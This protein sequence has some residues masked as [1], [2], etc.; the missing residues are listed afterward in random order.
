MK[1]TEVKT[2]EHLLKEYATP[3]GQQTTGNTGIGSVAKKMAGQAGKSL[4]KKVGGSVGSATSM[5][6]QAIKGADSKTTQRLKSIA[7]PKTS[8]AKITLSPT[9]NGERNIAEPV[10]KTKAGKVEKGA[11]IY[12]QYGNYAG[13]VDSPLGDNSAGAGADAVAILNKNN[14]YEVKTGDDEVFVQNPEAKE[15]DEGK[16]SKIANRRGKKRKIKKLKRI[17]KKI[18][19]KSLKEADPK[20]F[21]I[22]FNRQSVAKEALDAPVRCGFEAE[23]FFYNAD[24][25]TASDDV[26]NMSISDVEYEFGDLP[27]SAYE[28]YQ[29]WLREKAMDE[30]LPDLIDNWIEENRDE[31]EYIQDFMDSGNGPTEDAVEEY[32]ENY[33]EDN[34]NE[35]ENREE[36]GWELDNW[37]R[38]FINEEYEDEYEDFLRDI[39]NDEDHLV[40][41]AIEEAEGDY[42][43][44]EYVSD[45]YYSMSE[46]LDDFSYDYS[47]ENAGVDQVADIL[48]NWI[49]KSSEFKDYPEVGDYGDTYTT[50][51]YS[52]EPDSSIEADEGAGAEIISPVFSSPR[53]MLREMKSL[54]EWGE[55]QFGT[56]NSTGLHVTMSWQAEKKDPN[57]LKMALLLGDPYLLA[58]FGRLKNTYTKSQYNSL[59]KYASDIQKGQDNNLKALE[60]QLSKGIDSGKFN[61]IHFK[62]ERDDSTGNKLIEFRIAGGSDYSLM[63]NEIVKAVVRYA[64]VMK[65]GYDDEA[66]KK[67]YI[68][69]LYRILNKSQEP[70][71]RDIDRLAKIDHPVITSAKEIVSKKEYFDVLNKL[72]MSVTY[73]DTYKKL[74]QPDA[75]K[76]WKQSIKDYQKGT[77]RDPSWMGESINEDEITGYVE[78]D[79]VMPSKMAPLKL[80]QAQEA[81]GQA[82]AMLAKQL[83]QKTARATP[84][85]VN[86]GHFRKY[87][88]ELKLDQKDLEKL[89]VQSIDDA[90]YDNLENDKEKHN[91]LQQGIAKLFKK[92]IIGKAEF[93]DSQEFDIIADGLW[94]Y[95]Q[96]EDAKDNLVLDKL[97]ELFVNVNPRNEKD[98]VRDE[99]IDLSKKRQKNEMYRYLSNN[100]SNHVRGSLLASDMLSSRKAIEELKAFLEKYSGYE[101]PVSRDHHINIRS[102]DNYGNVY[103]MNMIQKMRQRIRILNSMQKTD[104]T[105]YESI[106]K[107]LIKLGLNYL[108]EL[109]PYDPPPEPYSW[110]DTNGSDMMSFRNMEH[111]NNT[112][113]SIVKLGDDDDTTYNFSGRYDDIVFSCI[114]LSEYYERVQN[115]GAPKDKFLRSLIKNR[116]KAIKEFLSGF[117]KIFQA[118]GFAN[119]EKEIAGKNQLD[120]RNKDFEKNVRDKSLAEINIPAHSFVYI[121]W[122]LQGNLQDVDLDEED[123]EMND[124][125]KRT[126]VKEL[127]NSWSHQDGGNRLIY[128][129]PGAHWEQAKDANEG[130]EIID[131]ESKEDNFYHNWRKRG[132]QKILQ[133]FTRTYNTKFSR[134]TDEDEGEYKLADRN[135][136][137]ELN[138]LN[139]EVTRKGDS[140]RGAPGQSDLIKPEELEN[141]K[142]GEPINRSSAMMWEQSTE[143]AEQKRFDAFDWSSYPEEFKE[144][145]AEMMKNHTQTHGNFRVAMS[146]VIDKINQKE[147][148]IPLKK[149][150]NIQGMINAAGVEDMDGDSSNGIASKTN[151]SN[152]ADYLGIERGVNDQGPNLLKKVYDQYDGNHEW[153]PEP[154]P[155]ACCMPRWSSAVKAAYEYIKTNYNVSAGNYFRKDADG[156]DGDNVSSVHSTPDQQVNTDYDKA[157]ED[158]PGFNTM[159]QNGMQNYLVRGQV[160]DLVG[161]LNN[162]SNDNVFKSAVLNTLA[163]RFEVNPG[164]P[165]N[166]FQD[167]LAVTRRHGYE[168]VFDKFEKLPLEE[169]LIKLQ[170]IDS[171]KIDKVLEGGVKQLAYDKEWDRMHS[172]DNVQVSRP[173]PMKVVKPYNPAQHKEAM[174]KNKMDSQKIT[175]QQAEAQIAAMLRKPENQDYFTANA[176]KKR[177]DKKNNVTE[178]VPN[179]TKVRMINK[180]LSDHFP[181]SDLKK[182]MDAYFAIPDPQMLKDF[183]KR[184]AEAGDDVCLRPILRNYIQMKLHPKLH[185]AIN[186]NESKDDLIAKIDALPDDEGTKKL[187]NYIE[188]LIDDMGV[189]GKIQSLSNE[190]EVIDDIDVK[191]AINQIAKIIA[192][193]EMSPQ[194]RAQL[195]VDWKAD[196]LVN[197]DALLSTSTVSLETI[198]KGYGEKGES[199]VTELVDDLNQVVQYG[200]GPGEFALS[201]LSQRIEGIGASSGADDDG[202]EGKGDL[203]I[204]GKPI[205]LKTTRKNSARFNDRQVTA[206]DSY[207]SLVT[208]FFNKYDAKFKELEEQG[209]Q[210]R[211]KS[212]MQQNHVMA[213]LK[214]VPE[215]EKEVAN[216]ISNIFTALNVSGGP[217]ARYLAQGDKNQAM[218][219]IAQSNVNNYL[220]QKRQSGNLLG[221]LFL[222]L[223]KQ[224][225]TF[226]KEVSDLEGTGLRLHAKTNYLITTV[227]NPFANTSIVDTGA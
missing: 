26:D 172:R 162:P 63:Y 39:A 176:D 15:V 48:H 142:S 12:D 183:R 80:K 9:I 178:S 147:V 141:P 118:E 18:N 85:S 169:Q 190:L 82:V 100:H 70:S 69:A 40:D 213:F 223:N 35:Y 215:A 83:A 164:N 119:L 200:I 62:D 148:N 173:N 220:A 56:N 44:D 188:Q 101:H 66:Y 165:F 120:K 113:D 155:D 91:V 45:Q 115:Y 29:D 138:R 84:R 166:S 13:K 221:I 214:E 6:G 99:L 77:G 110:D 225:F 179:N 108:E 79:R 107:Q 131:R 64:T 16:L 180:I 163:N 111:W 128:V 160:N 192:S 174:I 106:K 75:D 74:I 60:N 1:F 116:F 227:E 210:V 2:L 17:L 53:Q 129:I 87:A 42:S 89:L 122:S 157:R 20:L 209:L 43:M 168:S 8:K 102:D 49:N 198:F 72:E 112:M 218:Q 76:K 186:L 217:I 208:A 93:F 92:D 50:S 46:F 124:W 206:S 38:D 103:Q 78:P 68:N 170:K 184:R 152:L 28:Y 189:G 195:F 202:P 94:Q 137:K 67:D 81:F 30:Y 22:N 219:L 117:D 136:Y 23:T 96:N 151:W 130:L 205:E 5:A 34:P 52:V 98:K 109:K 19:R 154:D 143:D 125:F 36:D 150:N 54:F 105:K 61:S 121:E 114:W 171:K 97:A 159:M 182:Q 27:D 31:D 59:L 88:G 187:V 204:D 90:N 140:R 132:Y 196:K 55:D 161:F 127:Q 71:E 194:E 145:V 156:N 24:S 86:I 95:F 158:H 191:K 153:R 134:L 197:V 65:A 135:F 226:I 199:H 73:F 14:K 201:V 37:A 144:A 167:A 181:A 123:N 133:K 212:G 175:R 41:D 224:A 104:Q 25:R 146:D 32:K 4:S 47:R 193:I 57:K 10:V 216:I 222:D 177:Q 58:E 139:V 7:S 21:E 3:V 185:S 203:L 126:V 207:K 51:A 11:D 33:K 149:Q 211:V